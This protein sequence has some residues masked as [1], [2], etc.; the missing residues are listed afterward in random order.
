VVF[1][2]ALGGVAEG[3]LHAVCNGVAVAEAGLEFG[4]SRAPAGE[5][6]GGVQG[7]DGGFLGAG[8]HDEFPA[9][10]SGTSAKLRDGRVLVEAHP[11]NSLIKALGDPHGLGDGVLHADLDWER[12]LGIESASSVIG[13]THDGR[14]LDGQYC[15]AP[16]KLPIWFHTADRSTN[17]V[18]TC[19][20]GRGILSIK[21][22]G[23]VWRTVYPS[24]KWDITRFIPQRF[25]P[26]YVG[27]LDER[28]FATR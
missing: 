10:D 14:L 22:D 5:D 1:G 4:F 17:W 23:C 15:W 20:Y 6:L 3:D 13:I 9:T 21:R 24:Y 25:R 7:E 2:G 8:F 18:A 26:Q 16:T 27:Q 19:I 12:F 11:E 28:I